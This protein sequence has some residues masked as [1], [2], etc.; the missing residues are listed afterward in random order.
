MFGR[1]VVAAALALSMVDGSGGQDPNYKPKVHEITGNQKAPEFE[2][3]EAWINSKPLK[4]SELKGKVVVVHIYAYGCIN[5]VR[6]L[7]WYNAWYEDYK[8]QGLA[9]IGIHTPELEHEKRLENVRKKVKEAK[10]EYP[11]A[12]D[13]KATMWKKFNNH[14]WPS[15]Y[16][17][18]KQGIAR[19]GWA[20]ELNINGVEGEKL[21]RE[22][23]ERLLKEAAR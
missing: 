8:D 13:A 16:L 20:G 9:M 12:V 4:F 15:I 14:Y 2:D 18:D 6:N 19:Y 23:I 3:I 17:I 22:K 10:M 5:C 7:P 21:M 11:I 1:L